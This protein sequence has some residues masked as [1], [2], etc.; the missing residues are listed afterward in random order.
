MFGDYVKRQ[1]KKILILK[2]G[3]FLQA[4]SFGPH[5]LS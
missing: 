4:P 5:K 2:I 1:H 3:P